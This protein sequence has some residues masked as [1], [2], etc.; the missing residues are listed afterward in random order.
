MKKI[1]LLFVALSFFS[2]NA[3]ANETKIA[4]V[5]FKK[6]VSESDQ[7]KE[8]LSAL[9]KMVDAK[10]EIIDAKGAEIK[11]LDEELAKQASVLTQESLK[12]KQGEREKLIRDYQRMVKD[13]ENELQRKE[14]EYIQKIS[15]E[16]KELLLKIGKDEGYT[17]IFEVVEGGIL[18]MPKEFDITDSVIKSFNK[19]T[20]DA[21]K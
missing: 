14:I 17:A 5:D 21:K 12:K 6:A 9:E 18:Y 8:A 19:A 15:M 20:G 3:E 16:L 2:L 1:I 13:S 4:Y 7:G 11:T 10:K